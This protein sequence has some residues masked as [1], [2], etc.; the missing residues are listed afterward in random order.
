MTHA[1]FSAVAL[2]AIV[3]TKSK[4]T[5]VCSSKLWR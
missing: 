3:G 1:P 2:L 5:A 4:R